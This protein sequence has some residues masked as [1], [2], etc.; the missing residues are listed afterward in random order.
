V[1]IAERVRGSWQSPKPNSYFFKLGFKLFFVIKPPILRV[2][3]QINEYSK[4]ILVMSIMLHKITKNKELN[5]AT[6]Y[7]LGKN[8]PEFLF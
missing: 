2:K 4:Y 3:L 5:L 1:D 6:N 8:L 7:Y